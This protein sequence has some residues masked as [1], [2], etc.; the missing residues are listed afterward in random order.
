MLTPKEYKEK[1][2]KIQARCK[3]YIKK[4]DELEAQNIEDNDEYIRLY[5]QLNEEYKDVYAGG[6]IIYEETMVTK[7]F[8]NYFHPNFAIK[9]F[10]ISLFPYYGK[11]LEDDS[12]FK[13]IVFSNNFYY[14]LTED[15]DGLHY[16]EIEYSTNAEFESKLEKLVFN[17]PKHRYLVQYT[18]AWDDYIHNLQAFDTKEEAEAFVADKEHWKQEFK[19]E[20]GIDYNSLR[21]SDFTDNMEDWLNEFVNKNDNLEEIRYFIDEI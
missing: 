14:Y 18:D 21:E 6:R 10:C 2:D 5:D 7:D 3:E 13:G 9:L 1:A 4:Y 17:T 12:I 20:F 16:Y 19:N 11:K 8:F 15:K